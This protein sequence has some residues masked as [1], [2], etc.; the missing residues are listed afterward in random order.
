MI[1]HS[2]FS[3]TSYPYCSGRRSK[4]PLPGRRPAI[5]KMSDAWELNGDKLIVDLNKVDF[6]R[7]TGGSKRVTM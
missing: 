3:G 5:N 2:A 7:E 1:Q 4:Q 6:L